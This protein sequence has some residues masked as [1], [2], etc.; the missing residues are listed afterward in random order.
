MY[1]LGPD[2]LGTLAVYVT[3]S[4]TDPLAQEHCAHTNAGNNKTLTQSVVNFIF[5][6]IRM[7][8]LGGL[9]V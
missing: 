7:Y 8:G 5:I 1:V 3:V 6:R 2:K 9:L 4:G